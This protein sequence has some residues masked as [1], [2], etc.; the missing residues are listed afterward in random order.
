[1]NIQDYFTLGWTGQ[2]LISFRPRDSQESSP[3]LQLKSINS[4]ALSFLYGPTLTSHTRQIQGG[5]VETVT[6]FIGGGPPKLLQ[7]VIATM[8]LKDAYSLEEKL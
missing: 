7:M 2:Q 8:K 1:M 3:T 5:K 4:L 6:D